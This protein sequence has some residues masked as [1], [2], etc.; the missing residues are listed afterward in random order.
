MRIVINE[1]HLH[2]VIE[3]KLDTAVSIINNHVTSMNVQLAKVKTVEDGG[4][5]LV[6]VITLIL[7]KF[8]KLVQEKMADSYD[9]KEI[10]GV[11]PRLQVVGMAG[12][13]LGKNKIIKLGISI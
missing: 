12:E 3:T 13:R 8:K 4:I 7:K 2:K 10:A 1:D 6:A 11:H 5:L 9:V